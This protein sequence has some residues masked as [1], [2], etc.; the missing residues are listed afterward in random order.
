VQARF[1][2]EDVHIRGESRTYVRVPEEGG[3]IRFG[4]CPRCG[5]TV[6]YEIDDVEGHIAIPVGAFADPGF[7]APW[8]SVYEERMHPWVVLPENVEH[9]P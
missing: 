8:V 6:H 1:R 5:A 4:F 7:P 9:V 3:E 2:S